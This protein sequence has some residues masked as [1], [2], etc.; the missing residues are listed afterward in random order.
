MVPDPPPPTRPLPVAGS[1]GPDQP[2]AAPAMSTPA[3]TTKEKSGCF[4]I[5]T[6]VM[7]G[8]IGAVV[9]LIGGCT[10]FIAFSLDRD[11]LV[12]IGASSTTES[13]PGVER[14]DGEA[15]GDQ[16]MSDGGETS[17]DAGGSESDD[18]VS[19]SRVDAD[20]IVLEVVNN[21]SKTSSYVLTIGFFDDAGQRLA[22]EIAFLNYLRPGERAIEEQF[23][24]EERGT[25]CEVIDADRFAAESIAAEVAEISDCEISGQPDV[26]GDF[27][28]T[29]SAT[30]GSP[31]TSDYSIEVAFV[32]PDG[33]RRGTGSAFIEAVR[34]G[35]TAP[36]DLFSSANFAEGYTCELIGV[37]RN[38][39]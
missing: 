23:V 32:D 37:I 28:A 5:A 1:A 17:Q 19:C 9:L 3:G 39:S 8:I 38:A 35:E 15:S 7:F 30:N 6:G 11:E 21:S 25:V 18:I 26:F 36:G 2:L 33:I 27:Q 24:F 34:P 16:D 20:A 22:D 29:V 4:G 31:E 13:A 10:A 12:S 14:S